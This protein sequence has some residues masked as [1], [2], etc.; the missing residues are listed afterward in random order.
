M[1][2]GLVPGSECELSGRQLAHPLTLA[3]FAAA[4][5]VVQRHHRPP[6]GFEPH[7]ERWEEVGE[8]V[9]VL[10]AHVASLTVALKAGGAL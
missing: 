6:A 3:D 4:L 7:R 10:A 8:R 2:T 5:D 1:R 9:D